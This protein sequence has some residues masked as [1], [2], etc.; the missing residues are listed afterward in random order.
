MFEAQKGPVTSPPSSHVYEK[1][2]TKLKQPQPA[3][4]EVTAEMLWREP[5]VIRETEGLK[6]L[7]NLFIILVFYLYA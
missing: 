2:A 7:L 5:A 6:L 3:P 1:Y 4:P